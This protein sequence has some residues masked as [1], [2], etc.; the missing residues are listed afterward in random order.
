[1]FFSKYIKIDAVETLTKTIQSR[2]I[3]EQYQI[4]DV[5]FVKSGGVR[6]LLSQSKKFDMTNGKPIKTLGMYLSPSNEAGDKINTCHNATKICRV[7]CLKNNGHMKYGENTR[8]Q[9]TRFFYGY[10]M[11]FLNILIGEIV[12]GSQ[13]AVNE[14][15]NV[16]LNGTSDIDWSIYINMPLLLADLS[17]V[18]G[19]YDYTKN[20]KYK[21]SEGYQITFSVS[22]NTSLSEA[23]GIIKRGGSIAIVTSK[24]EHAEL[25]ALNYS[26]L[27]NGDISDHRM[28]DPKGSI[29]LLI[30]KGKGATKA[31]RGTWDGFVKSQSFIEAILEGAK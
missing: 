6:N 15:V 2:G 18:N 11:E 26:K 30:Y 20:P 7:I 9:K 10:P 24:T 13:K 31:Q 25:V 4:Q 28:Q 1:M 3:R 27:I 5:M 21:P 8:I 12:S 16:R 29:V 14:T 23:Q 19:F 17:N 22:E